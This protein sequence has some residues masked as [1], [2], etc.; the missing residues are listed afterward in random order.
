M[1]AIRR[2]IVLIVELPVEAL[3]L[4]ILLGV[5]AFP[6]AQFIHLIAGIWALGFAV[7]VVLFLHGYYL[8]RAFFGAV[9]RSQRPW[10]YPA[11]A[12]T[13][14]VAHVHFAFVRG[15]PDMSPTGRA[16]ELPFLAGGGCIVFA[17]AFAGNWLLRRWTQ[18]ANK[19]T[20]RPT[21]AIVA[22]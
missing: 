5:L 16:I 10:I 2:I 13:L 20:E 9:W 14:F 19:P 15:K 1:S 11:L 3:L 21:P 4:G 8:T 7:A 6:L 22:D 17:C 18:S 12:A